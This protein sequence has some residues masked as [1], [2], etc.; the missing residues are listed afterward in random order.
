MSGELSRRL[1]ESLVEAL[2]AVLAALADEV[3]E[4]RPGEGERAPGGGTR[5]G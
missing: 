5:G 2:E 1:A 4:R 3:L